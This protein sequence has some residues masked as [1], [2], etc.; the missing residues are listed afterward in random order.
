MDCYHLATMDCEKE[1][2]S[3]LALDFIAAHARCGLVW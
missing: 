3:A 1:R 2:V